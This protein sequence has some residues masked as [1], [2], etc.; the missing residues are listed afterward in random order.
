MYLRHG[1]L[2][3][4]F[5]YVASKCVDEIAYIFGG[6]DQANTGIWSS[7][8]WRSH[9]VNTRSYHTSNLYECTWEVNANALSLNF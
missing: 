1:G 4:N 2:R 5:E 7:A 9:D 3:R 6:T 8:S